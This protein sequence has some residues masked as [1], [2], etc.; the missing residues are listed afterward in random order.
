MKPNIYVVHIT[1]AIA[2]HCS[3]Q[4][5]LTRHNILQFEDYV[6]SF[7][8]YPGQDV[9]VLSKDSSAVQNSADS[10]SATARKAASYRVAKENCWAIAHVIAP[11]AQ[12]GSLKAEKVVN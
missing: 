9:S 11:I 10:S 1:S 4:I 7:W 12:Y 5:A 2:K 6:S 3:K 8:T